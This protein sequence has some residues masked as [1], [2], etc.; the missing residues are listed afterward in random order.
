MYVNYDY[1]MGASMTTIWVKYDYYMV[2][3][4]F[5]PSLLQDYA[6]LAT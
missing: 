5:I 3:L 6:L 4:L 2:Q 1:Y